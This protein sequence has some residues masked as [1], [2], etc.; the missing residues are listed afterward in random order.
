MTSYPKTFAIKVSRLRLTPTSPAPCNTEEKPER[1]VRLLA[2][3]A[4]K[5]HSISAS[6]RRYGPPDH[7]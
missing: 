1:I 7:F 2:C 4:W 6:A 5:P 3:K